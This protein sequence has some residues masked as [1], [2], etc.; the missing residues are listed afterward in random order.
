M[1]VFHISFFVECT[2]HL[3]LWRLKACLGIFVHLFVCS[4]CFSFKW[5]HDFFFPLLYCTIYTEHKTGL[6]QHFLYPQPLNISV[7]THPGP[8]LPS[9]GVALLSLVLHGKWS[10]MSAW[11]VYERQL[12][13]DSVL[14]YSFLQLW[15][16]AEIQLWTHFWGLGTQ[17]H[18]RLSFSSTQIPLTHFR[19]RF[20]RAAGVFLFTWPRLQPKFRRSS[21]PP[22]LVP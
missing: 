11:W 20:L 15:A 22:N 17:C 6:R 14:W 18:I 16:K 13:Q 19:L 9:H 12:R 10:R 1:C 5:K 8:W 2:D 4:F 21:A 3:R 7:S